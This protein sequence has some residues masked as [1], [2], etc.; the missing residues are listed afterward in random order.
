MIPVKNKILLKSYGG[1]S[2]GRRKRLKQD[3]PPRLEKVYK[4]YL[5][6]SFVII[7][8]EIMKKEKG[9]KDCFRLL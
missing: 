6:K 7:M 5:Y 1:D 2:F 8:N 3:T 4:T 9:G